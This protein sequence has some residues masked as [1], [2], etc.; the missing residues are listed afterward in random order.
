MNHLSGGRP[1]TERFNQA[2]D[3]VEP[4]RATPRGATMPAAA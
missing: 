1:M 3:V 4:S 2:R